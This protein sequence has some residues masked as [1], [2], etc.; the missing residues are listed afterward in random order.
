MSREFKVGALAMAALVL[1][2]IAVFALGGRSN[3]FSRENHYTVRF[4]VVGGLASESPV[5]IDGVIVGRVREVVLPEAIEEKLLTVRVSIESRY[6]AR[7]REDSLARI[8]TLG[9][10]GD[11]YVEISSGTPTA[12][13]IPPGGE[14]P[15]AAPTDVDQLIA[16]G[17][18][19]VDNV[20]AISKALRTILVRLEE[21]EGVIGELLRETEDSARA[22]ESLLASIESMNSITRKIDSGVGTLGR[23][24]NDDGLA[25]RVAGLID[26]LE[27][28]AGSLEEGDGALAALLHDPA[29]KQQVVDS[30]D[31]F[32]NSAGELS[33]FTAQLR[34]G[35][36]LLNRLVTDEE[37]GREAS[38]DLR[39]LL[40]NLEKISGRLEAGEGT[41]GRLLED[42]AVYEALEDVVVGIDQSAFLRWLI[43]NR[44]RRGIKVRYDEAVDELEEAGLEPEPVDGD[45]TAGGG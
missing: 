31:S 8:K 32:S 18:D 26:R 16:S 37:L 28:L 23:L 5:Q 19:M 40:D 44:Q 4:G 11:K 22:R 21:G 39:R 12:E 33:D 29:L 14:I 3:L 42:P 13:I 9:L 20:L 17:E 24:I 10:L 30:I 7:V 41:I 45:R 2:A 27:S 36:G 1:L 15:A 6:A 25:D 35:D 43:R 38:E 34:N